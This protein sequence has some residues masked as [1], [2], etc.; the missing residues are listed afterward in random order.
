MMRRRLGFYFLRGAAVGDSG[1]NSV[2]DGGVGSCGCTSWRLAILLLFCGREEVLRFPMGFLPRAM[3][4]APVWIG[5]WE[6]SSEEYFAATPWF[7]GGALCP[8]SNRIRVGC[9]F[10]PSVVQLPFWVLRRPAMWDSWRSLMRRIPRCLSIVCR[11]V[12]RFNNMSILTCHSRRC[13]KKLV[14][15]QGGGR[16]QAGSSG[17]RRRERPGVLKNWN[18]F[19]ILFK[20]VFALWAVITEY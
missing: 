20:G 14:L 7:I 18:V 16:H 3:V 15:C 19:S 11:L 4:M 10:P 2:G 17:R 8:S 1:D 12:Q 5:W 9:L 6:K 13:Q